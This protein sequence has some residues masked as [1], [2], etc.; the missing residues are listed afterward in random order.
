MTMGIILLYI[1]EIGLFGEFELKEFEFDS[2][3]L[4]LNLLIGT[5]ILL[6]FNDEFTL[7]LYEILKGKLLLFSNLLFLAFV[8]VFFGKIFVF[9]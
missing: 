1:F 7:F 5:D 6:K 4:N 3:V 8:N 9:L 2:L